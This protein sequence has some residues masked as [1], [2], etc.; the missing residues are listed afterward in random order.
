[1]S[2]FRQWSCL[3]Y[4]DL[5]FCSFCCLCREQKVSEVRKNL[6]QSRSP[7]LE[8]YS[9]YKMADG[10]STWFHSW[11]FYII[12]SNKFKNHIQ[13]NT[14]LYEYVNEIIMFQNYSVLYIGAWVLQNINE[15]LPG[16]TLC[17]QG[18]FCQVK[19]SLLANWLR[20]AI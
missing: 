5:S 10:Q 2:L 7:T 11:H 8:I 15:A 13:Y 18:C 9:Y 3:K 20:N 19:V 1:M 12:F 14:T 17:Q 4:V 16:Q 6:R